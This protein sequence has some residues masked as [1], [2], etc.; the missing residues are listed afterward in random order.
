MTEDPQRFLKSSF[1]E[2]KLRFYNRW[3]TNVY[4]HYTSLIKQHLECVEKKFS[5]DKLPKDFINKLS[6]ASDHKLVCGLLNPVQVTK[7]GY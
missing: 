5:I 4:I 1:C 7:S 2:F 6:K 3:L